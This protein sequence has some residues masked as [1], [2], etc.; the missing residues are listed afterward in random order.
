MAEK[1]TVKTNKDVAS[2]LRGQVIGLLTEYVKQKGIYDNSGLNA[3]LKGEAL[4]AMASALQLQELAIRNLA[5]WNYALGLNEKP[6]TS[7]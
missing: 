7:E 6:K 3:E 5:N 4:Q 1:K 2:L